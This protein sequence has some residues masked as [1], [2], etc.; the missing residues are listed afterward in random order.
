M[1]IIKTRRYN[2]Q[3]WELSNDKLKLFIMAGGGHLA[4]LQLKEKP[5]VNPFWIPIW[6]SLEPGAYRPR[7]AR[8][9]AEKLLACIAGHN[10]CLGM[11]GDPS[12]EETKAGLGCHGEAPIVRWQVLKRKVTARRLIFQY[13]C[14]LPV[15]QMRLV[16]TVTL[17]AGSTIVRIRELLTNLARRD[18]PFTICQHVTFGAPFLEPEVTMFDLSA[19]RGH[20]FPVSF[21]PRQRLKLDTS[22]TWP[23]APGVKGKVNLRFAGSS[24]Y[25]DFT[26]NLMNPRQNHAWFSAVNPRL[27]MLVAYIW[28]R[29]DFPWLGI[30]EE[31]R[32]RKQPPWNGKAIA[33]GM[34]FSNSPFPEG[35]RQAVDRGRFQGLPTFRWLPALGQITYNYALLALPV[36]PSCRG[37]A[38]IRPSGKEFAVD[39]IS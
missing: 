16:R 8:R 33:R 9:Y 13:G 26:A 25:G 15:A 2:R 22:F 1:Q 6:K 14:V 24:R 39:L 28:R 23:F 30:W 18:V 31:N 27:G 10:L 21:S 19:T 12:P 35:L 3:G 32:I 11:F 17:E 5:T 34:E 7:D 37:V 36:K 20:T 38:A 4:G 29:A